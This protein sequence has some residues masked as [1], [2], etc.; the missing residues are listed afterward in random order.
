LCT[1]RLHSHQSQPGSYSATQ[2]ECYVSALHWSPL[3]PELLVVAYAH[4]NAG[5]DSTEGS[6]SSIILWYQKHLHPP[7]YPLQVTHANQGAF[8]SPMHQSL[9]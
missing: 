3:F 7:F 4:A 5:S 8:L 9:L 6:S 2:P 1:L